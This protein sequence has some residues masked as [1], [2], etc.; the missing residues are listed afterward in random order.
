MKDEADRVVRLL[1][2]AS[3]EIGNR[4]ERTLVAQLT[5]K[6]GEPFAA[7]REGLQLL[8]RLR[9]RVAKGGDRQP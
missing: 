6:A 3:D 4:L 9:P 8:T 1:F 5:G 7:G 2:D